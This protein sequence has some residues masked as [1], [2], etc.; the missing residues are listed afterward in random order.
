MQACKILISVM[1]TNSQQR[2]Q[3]NSP[4]HAEILRLPSNSKGTFCGKSLSHLCGMA[5]FQAIGIYH[6]IN[7]Y[8]KLTSQ[9]G[10]NN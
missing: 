8:S 9:H 6:Y 7:M 10:F 5:L 2:D 4:K 3:L 1:I